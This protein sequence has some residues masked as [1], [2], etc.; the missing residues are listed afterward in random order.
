M[1]MR[2]MRLPTLDCIVGEKALFGMSDMRA[3]ALWGVTIEAT[4]LRRR[5]AMEKYRQPRI[6]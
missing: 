2:A 1:A 4:E 5:A 3:S 6:W